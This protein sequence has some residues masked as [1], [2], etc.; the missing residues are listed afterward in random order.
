MATLIRSLILLTLI[1][2]LSPS[3]YAAVCDQEC[4]DASDC[5]GSVCRVCIGHCISCHELGDQTSCADTGTG[6]SSVCTWMTAENRCAFIGEVPE[7]PTSYR[8]LLFVLIAVAL[9]VQTTYM[10]ARK[11]RKSV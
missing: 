5:T 11:R 6:A 7:M 9:V 4:D 2:F 10:V 1:A 3:A 8:P